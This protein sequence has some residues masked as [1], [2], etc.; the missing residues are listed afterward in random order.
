MNF[1]LARATVAYNILQHLNSNQHFTYDIYAT[2]VTSLD[3][4]GLQGMAPQRWQSRRCYA[5]NEVGQAISTG[6]SKKNNSEKIQSNS[7]MRSRR[8]ES[9]LQSKG[10]KQV[11]ESASGSEEGRS[12]ETMQL[13][14]R[15]V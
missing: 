9:R 1:V 13:K 14:S 6:L 8:E 15:C 3:R 7:G 11:C 4:F 5:R 2:Y 10:R 12:K